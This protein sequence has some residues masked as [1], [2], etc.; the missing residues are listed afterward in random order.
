MGIYSTREKAEEAHRV[1]ASNNPIEE[2]TLDHIPEYPPGK[3]KYSVRVKFDGEILQIYR[4]SADSSDYEWNIYKNSYNNSQYPSCFVFA[5]W[6]EDE[7]AAVKIANEKRIQL[8]A[9][10]MDKITTE[11]WIEMAT[12]GDIKRV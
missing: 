4:L 11:D 2:L 8:L 12:K 1:Y 10:N 3:L 5:M 6:A 9:A 7:K